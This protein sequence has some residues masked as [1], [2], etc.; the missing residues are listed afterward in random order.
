MGTNVQKEKY[1]DKLKDISDL[2]NLNRPDVYSNVDYVYE[3][4]PELY[5]KM[6]QDLIKSSNL[7]EGDKENV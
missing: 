2:F 3:Q 7:Y 4:N 5:E 1:S 6:K